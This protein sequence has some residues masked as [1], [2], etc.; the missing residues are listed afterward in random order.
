[1]VT[2]PCSPMQQSEEPVHPMTQMRRSGIRLPWSHD[3]E[4]EEAPATG[5]P[6]AWSAQEPGDEKPGSPEDGQAA[7]AQSAEVRAT[8]AAPAP[9]SAEDNELLTSLITAMREVAERERAAKV[10]SLKTTVEEAIERMKARAAEQAA[11]LRERADLDVAGIAEWVKSET[12]RIETEG[13]TKTDARHAQLTEQLAEHQRHSDSSMDAVRGRVAEY[14]TQLSTFF[15]ELEAINDPAV[16][17]AA[18]KRMPRPPSL[19]LPGEPVATASPSANPEAPATNT[20]ETI[21]TAEA[22]ATTEA[23]AAPETAE[24]AETAEASATTEAEAAPETAETAETA[25]TGETGE[26]AETG[27]TT[28]AEA[29]AETA[30]TGDDSAEHTADAVTS[31]APAEPAAEAEMKQSPAETLRD[32]LDALGIADEAAPDTEATATTTAT[33]E[34]TEADAT[35]S[36]TDGLA[37]RLAQLDARIGAAEASAAPPTEEAPAAP[38]VSAGPAGEVA[39][40]IM[41][42]GLGSFGAITS[43]KQALER[44]EGVHGISLSL[45]PTGEFVYR[46]THDAAFDIAAAIEQIEHGTAKI[47]RQD[48]GSLRVTVQRT[49]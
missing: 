25:E 22:G 30:E 46:A 23:A 5:A 13:R 17:G 10:T 18:A 12:E 42:S 47:D 14:E 29:A 38:A 19:D 6:E 33:V 40:P 49:R 8:E 36:G 28:E 48:D 3:D 27:E 15:A 2:D 37:A 43:F 21:E 39:T 9:M 31:Q 32:R 35:V 11:Q 7:A 4:G 45:G 34:G 44:V 16:F 26:T 1:M 24:T 41:V 20:Y